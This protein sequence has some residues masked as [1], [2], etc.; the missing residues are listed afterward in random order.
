MSIEEDSVNFRWQRHSKPKQYLPQLSSATETFTVSVVGPKLFVCGEILRH[1]NRKGTCV[2]IIDSH[3][4]RPWTLLTLE[5]PYLSEHCTVL[6]EDKLLLYGGRHCNELRT[7][8]SDLWIFDLAL[9]SFRKQSTAGKVPV[10]RKDHCGHLIQHRQIGPELL[11]FGGVLHGSGLDTNETLCLD[12]NTFIWKDLPE[13]GRRPSARTGH[14]STTVGDAM[15][16][17]G[18]VSHVGFCEDLHVLRRE[19]SA[20]TGFSGLCWS[21]PV[22]TGVVPTPLAYATLSAI[23]NRLFLF[24]GFSEDIDSRGDLFVYTGSVEKGSWTLVEQSEQRY[25]T[26]SVSGVVPATNAHAA[27]V[28]PWKSLLIFGGGQRDFR[29]VDELSARQP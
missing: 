20:R 17:F 7:H 28:S 5:G 1:T 21:Q 6:V 19:F 15:F 10:W 18:G 14:S 3:F 29:D 24:G 13:R 8:D 23:D 4:S 26:Y 11:V 12:L 22:L 27:A 9:L 2:C 25:A 16:V